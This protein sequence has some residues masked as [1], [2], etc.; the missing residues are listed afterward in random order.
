MEM[1]GNW[2]DEVTMMISA[3]K[4]DFKLSDQEHD[5]KNQ[6]TANSSQDCKSLR[7][8]KIDNR[9]LFRPQNT[10]FCLSLSHN[11]VIDTKQE[12]RTYKMT[13]AN[14]IQSRFDNWH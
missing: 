11:P 1:S 2:E 5:Q 3:G 8:I 7:K 4:K 10:P 14:V 6:K 9:N 12:T 13:V